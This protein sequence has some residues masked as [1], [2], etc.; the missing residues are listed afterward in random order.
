MISEGYRLGEIK[1]ER[2]IQK[3]N[4]NKDLVLQS[5][6]YNKIRLLFFISNKNKYNNRQINEYDTIERAYKIKNLLKTLPTYVTWFKRK[7][8]MHDRFRY[9]CKIWKRR[10]KLVAYFGVW[11]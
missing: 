2:K 7:V 5:K 1:N 8:N 10:W 9:M 3:W 4:F 11:M 6:S